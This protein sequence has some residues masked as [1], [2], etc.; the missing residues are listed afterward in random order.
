M[1][2]RN[3]SITNGFIVSTKIGQGDF[4]TITAACAVAPSGTI[5]GVM[6]GTYTENFTIPAG[7]VLTSMIDSSANG[8]V[9]IV[10]TPTMT[11]AGTSV[12]SGLRLQTNSVPL[13]TVSGSNASILK[14]QN[15]YLNI[16]NNDGISYTNSNAASRI[17]VSYCIGDVGT[18]GIKIFNQTSTGSL[19]IRYTTF[20]NTGA[21]VTESTASAGTCNF[22]YSLFA[23]PITTSG[24]ALFG[25][26]W[27]DFNTA[28]TNTTSLTLGGSGNS[29]LVNSNI[30]SGSASCISIGS[31]CTLTNS[32][33]TSSN[34][35]AITGAGTILYGSNSYS[36]SSTIN[37]STQTGITTRTGISQSTLQPAFSGYLP[38]SDLNVT[39][40]GTVYTLGATTALTEVFDQGSNFT[41]GGVFT[42]PLTGR[43]HLNSGFRLTAGTAIT[44]ITYVNVTSNRSYPWVASPAAAAILASQS[45][46]FSQLCDMDAGDTYTVTVACT[47]SGGKNTDV[48]GA[49]SFN[50][51][52]SGYL[53][54]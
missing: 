30:N 43:Y 15:C 35:I 24:T 16:T 14:I 53:E 47:D 50:S 9:V 37:T 39:G 23:S 12:I 41:T 22:N 10:G 27:C 21:S 26:G 52:M 20:T 38:S 25:V 28:A 13:A 51:G 42:A 19:I 11:A 7:I 5:I 31:T 46:S 40:D 17:E 49:A 44:A 4:T 8:N 18:T 6:S 1:S 34:P 48:I 36:S 45:I 33:I 29:N 3:Y 2:Y 54:C 32:F